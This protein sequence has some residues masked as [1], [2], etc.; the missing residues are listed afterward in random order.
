MNTKQHNN[1]NTPKR[2]FLDATYR[3]FIT[4]APMETHKKLRLPILE[5]KIEIQKFRNDHLI[6]T[7]LFLGFL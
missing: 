4:I 3:F 5:I 6:Q 1:V 7:K 2:H